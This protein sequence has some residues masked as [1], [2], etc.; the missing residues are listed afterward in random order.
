MRI[1][2]AD[3]PLPNGY[4]E[5]VN[6]RLSKPPSI[7]RQHPVARRVIASWRRLHADP[8]AV[9]LVACS[10]GADSAAL[11]LSLAAATDRLVVGCVLHDMRPVEVVEAEAAR[12]RS[13]AAS[14]GV[15]YDERRVVTGGSGAEGPA[16]QAR[17]SALLEMA[18][19][20]DATSIAT[21]HH[22]DDQF[23]SV[24]MG[25]LRGGGPAALAGVAPRRMLDEHIALIRPMLDVTRDETIE[26]CATAGWEP[27]DDATNHATDR[28]RAA[29][30]HGP[31]RDIRVIRPDAPAHASRTARLMADLD[32]L[33]DDVAGAVFGEDTAWARA[34]LRGQREVV[35]AA[36]L[37]RAAV[38]LLGGLG[39]DRIG[40]RNIDPVVRAVKDDSTEPRQFE[41]FGGVRV[42]VTA[43]TVSMH[44]IN[45]DG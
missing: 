40:G 5:D 9:T 7:A 20:H 4:H 24:I 16:R 39:A 37:R 8:E 35:I 22:A 28:L 3:T 17:Y 43:S 23:E 38:R 21:G 27:C 26:L 30:R 10:G 41:W 12:V 34:E 42:D 44:R 36:G 14:L 2:A 45:D 18:A 11:L 19:A 31:L 32:G 6:T 33:L 15:P 13:L 1:R 25:L 29:L